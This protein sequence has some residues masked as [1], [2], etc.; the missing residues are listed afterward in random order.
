MRISFLLLIPQVLRQQHSQRWVVRLFFGLLLCLGLG[1]H[2]DYGMS[3]DEV[4]NHQNGLVSLNYVAQQLAPD[5]AR[6]VAAHHSPIPNIRD[7]PD[8][9]H[10]PLFEMAASVL[11]Y[12][13]TDGDSR[14]V[15]FLRHLLVFITFMLGAW[16]L[17][18][19]GK[20]RFR[21][22]RW[23]LL[24][25]LLLV[26]S[27]RFF[28][29]AFY[30]GKDVVF[31]S[32]F[33]LAVAGLLWLRRRPSLFRAFVHGLLTA[34]ATDIRV[35]GLLIILPT[36]FVLLGAQTGQAA[37]GR[38][39]LGLCAV[40]VVAALGGTYA[41]WP[42]L[43]ATPLAELLQ[44]FHRLHSYPWAFSVLY[45]GQLIPATQ[46]PWHYVLVWLGITTPVAY[47]ALAMAGTAASLAQALRLRG[48][49]LRT[50]AGQLDC[51]LLVWLLGPLAVVIGTHAVLYD[52]WR[53]LYFI[54]PAFLLLAVKGLRELTHL[55]RATRP[56][57]WVA[58]VV[59]LAATLEFP[60]TVVRMVRLHPFQQ[61][62]FSFLP[63]TWAE[64]LFERDYWGLAYRQGLEWLLQRD[65][66]PKLTIQVP[67]HYPLYNNSLILR[68]E[69]RARLQ[70]EPS[71]RARYFITGY[72]WH[73]QS[74]LDSVGHEV[75]QV[76]A[77]GV[78]ILS[79]FERPN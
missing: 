20:Q 62:Y 13:L 78:K 31:M 23:G 44:A 71:A 33:T 61:V 7:F 17:Y 6:R 58:V 70:Y 51:W 53:H 10:G 22:W 65:A 57:R 54:Y 26:A 46:L 49:W 35:Q 77:G 39:R 50:A 52:G 37:A 32:L 40:Y 59:L 36:L 11:G 64:Q 4:N 63:G 41:G 48:R 34:M 74:Y 76:R 66:S 8:S 45:L 27:P 79:I 43:W 30:N 47:S 68:P 60:V 69:E 29:E 16:G 1:L 24:G 2:R 9:D 42:Y 3:W 18:Y 21:D 25:S 12:A 19:I 56:G 15:Y 28:A 55:A 14:S 67:W 72:R 5:L 75:H 38:H 73:P